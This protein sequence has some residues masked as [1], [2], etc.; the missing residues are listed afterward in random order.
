MNTQVFIKT[1]YLK[2]LNSVLR[3]IISISH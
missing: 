3:T 2:S 1:Y